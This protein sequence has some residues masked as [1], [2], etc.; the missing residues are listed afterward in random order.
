MGLDV[1]VR[2]QDVEAQT[3]AAQIAGNPVENELTKTKT[4][5]GRQELTK[6]QEHEKL[7]ADIRKETDPAKRQS[8]IDSLLAL[9]GKNPLSDRYVKV[10]GGE[11]IGPDGMTKIRRPS[12][13][14]DS[15]TQKF[16]PGSSIEQ[17]TI[18]SPASGCRYVAKE[19][20]S[21]GRF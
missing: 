5:I 21:C 6:G 18:A 4:E 12:G 10:D 13:V 7:V 2:G 11:E 14:F 16:I 8:M 15:V 1:A 17:P 3:R 9:Q 19:S 20:G